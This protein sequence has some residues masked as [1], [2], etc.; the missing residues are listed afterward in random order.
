[1]TQDVVTAR[2]VAAPD[3]VA[4]QFHNAQLICNE[5]DGALPKNRRTAY[6]EPVRSLFQVAWA[7]A[8]HR[9]NVQV[10]VYH[11]AYALVRSHPEAGRELADCLGTD[12]ESFAVGCVLRFLTLGVST[13]DRDIVPPAVD[14]VRWLGEGVALALM[15]GEHSEFL[16]TDLVRAI[17]GNTIHRSVRDHLNR[18]ARSGAARRDAILGPRSV[19]S[20]PTAPPTPDNIIEHIK[21]V[22]TGRAEL[23]EDLAPRSTDEVA[24]QKQLLASADRRLALIEQRTQAIDA[25]ISRLEKIDRRLEGPTRPPS[26]AR[27]AAAIIGVLTL[28]VAVG[29]AL[30]FPQPLW[31]L[32]VQIFSAGVK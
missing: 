10:T 14:A 17:Q 18:A 7:A 31:S 12:A 8:S 21:E 4:L 29:L 19:P 32:L 16:P 23:L 6:S 24:E 25:A 9:R 13:G 5:L 20:I 3:E 22:E 2:D 30:Q 27:L 11:L 26:G 15:R 1:M 28:G